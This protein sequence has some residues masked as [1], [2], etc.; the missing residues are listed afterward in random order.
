MTLGMKSLFWFAIAAVGEIAGCYAFWMWL[1][2]HRDPWPL[3]VGIPALLVF[4]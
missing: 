1:R 4:A 2:Q 3:L